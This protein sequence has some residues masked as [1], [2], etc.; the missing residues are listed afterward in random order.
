MWTFNHVDG[1]VEVIHNGDKSPECR[2]CKKPLVA[3]N[4]KKM[5]IH[6][7]DG[8]EGHAIDIECICPECGLFQVFGVAV[9]EQ[10]FNDIKCM[11]IPA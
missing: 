2:F 1:G 10:D 5:H 9:S 8:Y 7:I 11:E 6:D 3:N 4:L